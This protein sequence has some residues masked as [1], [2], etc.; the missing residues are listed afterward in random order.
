MV[1]RKSRFGKTF[2]SCSNF[3]DCDVICNDLSDLDT[4]YP[5]HPK[6]AYVKK[7]GKGRKKADT[8]TKAKATKTTKAKATKET[9][10]RKSPQLKLS[11]EMAEFMGAPEVDAVMS[12]KRFGRTLRNKDCK[13]PQTSDKSIRTPSWPN[14][15]ETMTR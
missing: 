15:L 3:P 9:K 2:Y 11:P 7:P 13:T 1:T 6:T 4:K 14:S 5:D 10:P 12:R 8:K